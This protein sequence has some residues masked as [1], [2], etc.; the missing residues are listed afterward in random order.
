M[1][2]EMPDGSGFSAAFRAVRPRD[3]DALRPAVPGDTRVPWGTL[4]AA[5]DHR[6]RQAFCDRGLPS[7]AVLEGMDL[8]S[9]YAASTAARAAIVRV[10]EDLRDELSRLVAEEG[11]AD[12]S[13]PM[14]LAADAEDR[15]CRVCYAMAW[16]EEV[17][18]TGRLWPGTPLGD[19][20][21]S[22]TMELL[23]AA[24]PGYAVADLMAQVKLAEEPLAAL[25]VATPPRDVHAG[26]VFEGSTDVGGADAD[27]VV[28]R[29]LLEIK[30]TLTP[31]KQLARKDFW[32]L[33]GYPLL[34]YHDR[35]GIDAVA[36]Y[37]ARFGRLYVWTVA[38]YMDLFGCHVPI[39]ELRERCAALLRQRRR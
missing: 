22:L 7:G 38:E 34:D 5:F 35:F 24:V 30:A 20:D 25:R 36:L 19:A 2:A 27:L 11:T 17:F 1:A 18:R 12:R 31:S 29:T 39:E 8:A 28:G 6:I 9:A 15:L 3:A 4:G 14:L 16:F 33:V 37:L 23:L 21:G 10:A 13:R 26:P 32:Q